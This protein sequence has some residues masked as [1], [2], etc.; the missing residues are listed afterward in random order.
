MEEKN[1]DI[2][3]LGES[4]KNLTAIDFIN[5]E[6]TCR[7]SGDTSQEIVFSSTFRARLAAKALG[8]PYAEITGLKMGEFATVELKVGNFL[9]QSLAEE[10]TQQI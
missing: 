6:K 1:I 8:I 3:K 7:I 5:A 10:V 2:S 9:M 4:L